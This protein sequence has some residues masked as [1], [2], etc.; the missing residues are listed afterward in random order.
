MP[1]L[2]CGIYKIENIVTREI[3]IGQSLRLSG[4]LVAHFSNLRNGRHENQYLQRSFSKYGEKNFISSIL[5]YCEDFEL[6]YYEQK[7]VD[8][9]RPSYN[10]QKEC[11]NS[12]KGIKLS[13]EAREKISEANRK[14][15]L[16][17]K[18]KKN[19]SDGVKKSNALKKSNAYYFGPILKNLFGYYDLAPME[20]DP[21]LKTEENT[22]KMSQT[23]KTN[24]ALEEIKMIN[25][26]EDHAFERLYKAEEV[27]QILRISRTSAYRLLGSGELPAFRFAGKTVRVKESDL[28]KFIGNTGE[29]RNGIPSIA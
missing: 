6:T 21:N 23:P 1:K 4:R 3:Y 18:T 24:V 20:A 26:P 10:I 8:Y 16:S 22:Q 17:E 14:R 7:I 13:K 9:M 5:L 2:N 19:I 15:I 27:A 12:N 11:V 25:Q 28:L 29:A